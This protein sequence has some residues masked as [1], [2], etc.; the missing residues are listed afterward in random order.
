LAKESAATREDF[1][2]HEA[3]E[4]GDAGGVGISFSICVRKSCT[5]CQEQEQGRFLK[6][7]ENK[8][9]NALAY[10]R[11]Y[12]DISKRIIM[13]QF[14]IICFD[15]SKTDNISWD[16]FISASLE[17]FNSATEFF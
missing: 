11:I 1:I 6:S 4:E 15:L 17:F 5:I 10:Q 13:D 3:S 9:E 12:Q 16:F 7:A 2:H 14:R 8:T